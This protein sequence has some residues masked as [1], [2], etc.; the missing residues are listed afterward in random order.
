MNI[1]LDGE[2][3]DAVTR[4]SLKTM[5]VNTYLYKFTHQEDIDNNLIVRKACQDLLR[6][7]MTSHEAEDFINAVENEYGNKVS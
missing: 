3:V 4:H 5:L 2:F 7:C 6:Y 1:D